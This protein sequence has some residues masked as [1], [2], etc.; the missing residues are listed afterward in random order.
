MVAS[1]AQYRSRRSGSHA[2]ETATGR[3]GDKAAGPTGELFE[4]IR[5]QTAQLAESLG[6]ATHS[7]AEE[8]M[9]GMFAIKGKLVVF[10][11]VMGLAVGGAGLA[12]HG[13]LTGT[14]EAPTPKAVAPRVP[15]SIERTGRRNHT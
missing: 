8:A 10:V 4:D 1:R 15:A 14:S 6:R 3:E 2:A 5:T 12:G 13:A 7:L 9:A 11:V